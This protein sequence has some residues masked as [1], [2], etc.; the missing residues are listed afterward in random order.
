[1]FLQI[2][3]FPVFWRI[4]K[5]D[6]VCFLSLFHYLNKNE[7][8]LSLFYICHATSLFQFAWLVTFSSVLI[9]DIDL[10]LIAGITIAILTLLIRLAT[11]VL[12][13]LLFY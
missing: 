11:Y 9:L 7:L 1:M 10:G 8:M 5:L 13:L 4:S 12:K 6:G 2:S 3:D